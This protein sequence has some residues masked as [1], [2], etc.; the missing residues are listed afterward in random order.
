MISQEMSLI[1]ILLLFTLTI[2][3]KSMQLNKQQVVI[4]G[5]GIHGASVAY[6]LSLKGIK[7][8]IIEK[9]AIASAASGK[10][11]GF[12]A[13]GW[14]NGPTR[15]LHEKSYDMY[16]DLAAK[17]G[18][19]S[20][21]QISALQVNGR[22][23]GSNVASWL[24]RQVTST[25]MDNNVAQVTPL[26]LTEKLIQN[27]LDAGSELLIGDVTN[28]VMENNKVTGV[29]LKTGETIETEKVVVCMGPWSG[30]YCEDWFGLEVPLTGI[31]STSMVYKDV[32]ALE[33]EPY[34]CFCDEDNNACHIEMY[35]RVG[36]E[37]YLCGLGGSDYVTGDRLRAGGDCESSDLIHADPK[38]VAAASRSMK[39][40]SSLG[41]LTPEVTQVCYTSISTIM[42]YY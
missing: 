14:D 11:G 12:L 30:V 40:M 25:L 23:A 8:L 21:R 6:H 18:I 16:I 2:M 37:L 3:A 26:E 22:R 1:T 17:L 20:F 29:K 28:V 13:R 19:T 4:L 36:G 39:S 5:G 10:A 9:T 38:R 33:K 7:S 27:A 35:P 41:D 42:Q 15:Q 24:D 31:K 34:A 32:K